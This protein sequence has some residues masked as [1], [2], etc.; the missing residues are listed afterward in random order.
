MHVSKLKDH[1]DIII[2]R[3][4]ISPKILGQYYYN[5]TKIWYQISFL[6]FNVLTL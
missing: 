4:P 2:P 6:D 1:L 3:L 5:L